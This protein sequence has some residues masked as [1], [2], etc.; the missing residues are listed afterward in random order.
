LWNGRNIL[1]ERDEMITKLKNIPKLLPEKKSW[2]EDVRYTHYW[3]QGFNAC[4]D[5]LAERGIEVSIC[6]RC[7]SGWDGIVKGC[8]QPCKYCQFGI[9]VKVL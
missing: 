6:Q 2:K 7:D 4:L 9:I 1:L 8:K 5:L 3:E